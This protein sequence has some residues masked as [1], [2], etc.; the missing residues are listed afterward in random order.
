MIERQILECRVVA[1]G[2]CVDFKSLGE[3]VS[4]ELVNILLENGVKSIVLL[5]QLDFEDLAEMMQS[6]KVELDVD[7][8][9][10]IGIELNALWVK[11]QAHGRRE[12]RLSVNERT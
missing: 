1:M 2:D 4:L 6:S 3:T 9:T 12:I 7:R 10:L 5:S 8:K 11:S